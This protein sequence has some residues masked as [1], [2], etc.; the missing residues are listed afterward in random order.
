MSGHV[1]SAVLERMAKI[2]SY[3]R[4]SG[5]KPSKKPKKK[6]KLAALHGMAGAPGANFPIVHGSQHIMPKPAGSFPNYA[7]MLCYGSRLFGLVR[8]Q[9]CSSVLLNQFVTWKPPYMFVFRHLCASSHCDVLQS[10]QMQCLSQC[11]DSTVSKAVLD[12]FGPAIAYIRVSL[13]VRRCAGCSCTCQD[14]AIKLAKAVLCDYAANGNGMPPPAA[15]V[16]ADDDDIFGD[17][18]TDY[19]CELPKVRTVIL[20]HSSTSSP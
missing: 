19:V 20:Q 12:A 13:H 4:V 6:D 11:T 7:I 5:G 15:R 18:G 9:V 1:D 16:K 2:M 3:M 10:C 17:A 14:N 8:L